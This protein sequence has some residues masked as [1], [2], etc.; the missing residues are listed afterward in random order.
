MTNGLEPPSPI[1]EPS[2][3]Y[4][5]FCEKSDKN[6]AEVVVIINDL[7]GL[8]DDPEKMIK[9][10]DIHERTELARLAA[11]VFFTGADEQ[12]SY[13]EEI[14]PLLL[15]LGYRSFIWSDAGINS[16]RMEEIMMEY[17]HRHIGL[18]DELVYAMKTE[19]TYK[20]TE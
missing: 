10:E 14:K 16:K 12:L 13:S 15:Y 20:K 1:R 9:G 2:E 8:S 11:N 17:C 4:K 3:E 5:K 7:Y 19:P 18:Y 6:L